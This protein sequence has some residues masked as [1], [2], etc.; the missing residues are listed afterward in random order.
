MLLGC[1]LIEEGRGETRVFTT[2]LLPH[3]RMFDFGGH[4][5]LTLEMVYW[6]NCGGYCFLFFKCRD[7][8][9]YLFRLCM[10]SSR[11]CFTPPAVVIPGCL[12]RRGSFSCSPIYCLVIFL[13]SVVRGLVLFVVIFNSCDG[14]WSSFWERS[15]WRVLVVLSGWRVESNRLFGFL[16]FCGFLRLFSVGS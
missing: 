9:F 1:N 5:L 13:A 10:C 7:P 8:F 6:F 16:R 3:A 14:E 15:E 4:L 11:A 2:H 12:D